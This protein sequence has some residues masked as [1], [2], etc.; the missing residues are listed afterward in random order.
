MSDELVKKIRDSAYFAEF[1]EF[2]IAEIDKLD[3]LDG[4]ESLTNELAGEEAKI[5]S[6]AKHK[7]YDILAPFVD[8]VEKREPTKEAID[9]A[10]EKFGL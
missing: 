3:S 2:M 4:L 9:K 7:L 8:L 6:K 10:H 5:R 1:Q